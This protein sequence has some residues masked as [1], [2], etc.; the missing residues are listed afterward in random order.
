M[1]VLPE[2]ADAARRSSPARSASARPQPRPL[3]CRAAGGR[4]G[5]HGRRARPRSARTHGRSGRPASC[6]AA[7]SSSPATTC[8]RATGAFLGIL[9]NAA[10]EY[11]GVGY[12]ADADGGAF[13]GARARYTITFPPGGLP[14]VDAFWS[15]TV[16]DADRFLY[17]NEL[18][19]YVLGSRQLGAMAR[20]P[21][22]GVT[23]DVAHARP[24]R[25]PASRTGCPVRPARSS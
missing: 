15:I 23:I 22:G 19:R 24:A 5:R 2:D 1:P 7:A 3:R 9:G 4:G 17:A 8:Q 21:D 14:P 11:L 6:S 10:E 20:D 12:Q 16:Y 18:G 13:D 25:G